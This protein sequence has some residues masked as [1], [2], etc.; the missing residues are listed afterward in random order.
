MDVSLRVENVC[1]A[2]GPP[3]R[4]AQGAL[5]EPAEPA[6]LPDLRAMESFFDHL[7]E[8][9]FDIRFLVPGQSSTMMTRLRR[10]VHRASPTL[11]ELDILR[12]ILSRAQLSAR[13]RSGR[14]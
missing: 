7:E 14:D 5:C 3:S 9:L 6:P 13:N 2:R 12:G 1:Q 10:L 4:P 11:T 8:A